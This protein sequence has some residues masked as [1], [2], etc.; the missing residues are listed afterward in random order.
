MVDPSQIHLKFGDHFHSSWVSE[1]CEGIASPSGLDGLFERLISHKEVNLLPQQAISL[2][3]PT[4]TDYDQEPTTVEEQEHLINALLGHQRN[5]AKT[6]SSLSNFSKVLQKRL[7]VLQRV[8]QAVSCKH[9]VQKISPE[10]LPLNTLVTR[11]SE[12]DKNNLGLGISQGNDA[13]LELGVKTGINILFSLL[14]QNWV[15]AKQTGQFSFCND[16][17]QTAISVVENFPPLSLSNETKLTPLG[18]DSLNQINVFLQQAASPNSEADLTGQRLAAELMIALA[19]QRGSLRYVLGWIEMSMKISVSVAKGKNKDKNA[20]KINWQAFLKIITDMI[21]PMG[22]CTGLKSTILQD[23]SADDCGLVSLYYAAVV[24]LEELYFLASD[25]ASNCCSGP[26]ENCNNSTPHS[27]ANL[28]GSCGEVYVWGSNCTHQLAE[29]GQEKITS[30]KYSAVFTDCQQVEAGQ[31]CTFLIY[32]D[33]TVGACGKG[34]YGRLGLGDS[35]NC[36]VPKK[37]LFE[38]KCMKKISSS[39]GSDGHSLALTT[40]GEV[41]SWGDGDYGKLGHGTHSTQKIPKLVKGPLVGKIVKSVSAGYR[42][43]AAVTE[44]GELYT[45]GD[46]EFGR[47]GHDYTSSK[48]FPT[49][50]QSIESVGMVACGGSHTLAV[51]QDG[52]TIW[53]F[54][55]GENGKL[56]HGDTNRQ[57]KPKVIEALTGLYIRKVSCGSQSS[58]AVTSSGQ[59]YAWGC[60]AILGCGSAE[61]TAL[62]PRLVEDLQSKRVVDIACGDSHVIALTHE[63]EVYAWGNNAMGQCGQG[64]AQSPITR[65]KRVIG[66]EGV[67]IHQVS[68]GTSHSVAWTAVPTDRPVVVWQKPFCVDL[69]EATF[70][71]IRTFLENFCCSFDEENPP[72]PFHSH[73]EHRHFVQLC[74]KMLSTHLSLAQ[75]GGLTSS[76]LGTQAPL[77]RNLL[78]RLL[79]SNIPDHV[80]ETVSEILKVG[81]PL[82]LPPLRERM[83]LLHSLLPQGQGRW[84]SLSRG[85]QMQ[86]SLILT[87][88]YDNNHISTLL[89]FTDSAENVASPKPPEGSIDLMLAEILMKT[90]LRNLAN[91]TEEALDDLEKNL[92]VKEFEPK[93][94]M[95]AF[96]HLHNLLSSLH[97][98]LLA[99]CFVQQPW[100]PHD[101]PAASLL[102]KHTSL[103]C[104]VTSSLLQKALLLVQNENCNVGVMSAVEDILYNSP[105]GAMMFHIVNALLL[106]PLDWISELLPEILPLLSVIDQLC[107]LLP[108]TESLE[109]AELE[110]NQEDVQE[111]WCWLV[112]MERTCA[113]LI[114]QCL[115]GMLVG[116]QMSKQEKSCLPWLE[117]PVFGNGA[118]MSSNHTEEVI[119]L[120]LDCISK[121]QLVGLE[122]VNLS[123]DEVM[124]LEFCCGQ[125]SEATENLWETMQ[126]YAARED[127][128]TSE[129]S[130]DEELDTMTR[131]L[132]SALLKHCNLVKV[133]LYRRN[134]PKTLLVIFQYVFRVRSCLMQHHKAKS[135]PSPQQRQPSLE[136]GRPNSPEF[137]ES[138][139]RNEGKEVERS[140]EVEQDQERE[141]VVSD[142]LGSDD[143]GTIKDSP[144]ILKETTFEEE[145]KK[146]QQR[147]L[148]LLLGVR[149]AVTET[150]S[151]SHIKKSE[152]SL[153]DSSRSSEVNTTPDA[154]LKRRGSVPDLSPSSKFILD[155]TGLLRRSEETRDGTSTPDH[156]HRDTNVASLQRVKEM[157]RRLRWQQERSTVPHSHH[158]SPSIKTFVQQVASDLCKFVCGEK[159]GNPTL[160][161]ESSFSW[162]VEPGEMARALD[163]QQKKAESRLRALNQI[164]ELLSTNSAKNESERT[165]TPSTLLSS[166]HIQLLMGCFSFGNPKDMALQ[167]AQ[168]YHYQDEIRA[169]KTEVQQDIQLTVHQIYELLVSALIETDKCTII[170]Q[171]ETKKLLLWTIFS[172]TMKYGPSDISLAVS[173]GLLPLLFK[174]TL[175]NSKMTYLMPVPKRCLTL[176]QFDL[177]LQC[178]SSNLLNLITLTSGAYCD[179]LGSGVVQSIVDLLWNQLGHIWSTGNV[180][181]QD[182]QDSGWQSSLGNFLLFLKRVAAA[183]AIQK[184]LTSRKWI[185]RILSLTGQFDESGSIVLSNMRSRLIAFSVL[186]M[187][188]S[189]CGK[190]TDPNYMQEV[191]EDLFQCLADNMWKIPQQLE[192]QKAQEKKCGLQWKLSAGADL[193]LDKEMDLEET[194]IMMQNATFDIEKCLNCATE[195]PQVLVHSTSGKGYGLGSTAMVSGCYKWKILIV[196]E[197]KGNEGT[198]VGVSKW[199]IRD[200]THRTTTDMWLYRAYSGNLYHGGEQAMALNGFTQGDFIT[201]VLDMDAK[202]LSFGKNGEDPRIAF[203]D[204]DASELYPCVMFYSG[205]PGEKIKMTDMQICEGNKELLPGDPLCAPVTSAVMEANISMMR[206]LHQNEVW[207]GAINRKLIDQLTKIKDLEKA[208]KLDDFAQSSD[209]KEKKED[210]SKPAGEATEQEECPGQKEEKKEPPPQSPQGEVTVDYTDEETMKTL[211]SQVWPSL[212]LIGGLDPGLRVGGSCKHKTTSKKGTLMGVSREGSATVKVHWDDGDS[213]VSDVLLTKIEAL[214]PEP[215]QANNLSGLNARHLESLMKLACLTEDIPSA[216]ANMYTRR[217]NSKVQMAKQTEMETAR[218]TNALMRKLDEDIARVLE[219]EQSSYTG[220]DHNADKKTVKAPLVQLE[221]FDLDGA[222]DTAS[223]TTSSIS[224]RFPDLAGSEGNSATNNKSNFTAFD[225]AVDMGRR[226]NHQGVDFGSSSQESLKEP[227]PGESSNV[228]EE[229]EDHDSLSDFQLMQRSFIQVTALKA[230]NVIIQCNKFTEMLLVP[231]SD[232]MADSSKALVDGTV[233]RRDED[234]KCGLRSLMKKMVKIALCNASLLRVFTVSDLERAQSVLYQVLTRKNAEEEAGIPELKAKLNQRGTPANNPS[235]EVKPRD[236]SLPFKRIEGDLGSFIIP[237]PSI[238]CSLPLDLTEEEIDMSPDSRSNMQQTSILQFLR[239]ANE[240]S[241]NTSPRNQRNIAPLAT[242]DYSSPPPNEEEETEPPPLPAPRRY[243]SSVTP[244]PVWSRMSSA[245]KKP[246]HPPVRARSPSPP[247]PPIAAPLLEMGFSIQAIKK[248]IRETNVNGRE[249]SASGINTLAMWMLE[250]PES[251]AEPAPTKSREMNRRGSLESLDRRGLRRRRPASSQEITTRGGEDAAED[252]ESFGSLFLRRHRPLTRTRH[253]NLRCIGN[254][255]NDEDD[256]TRS[257]MPQPTGEEGLSLSDYYN[258][259]GM[260]PDSQDSLLRPHSLADL[261]DNILELQDEIYNQDDSIEDLFNVEHAEHRDTWDLFNALR[262]ELEDQT[263]VTCELCQ[264][265]TTNFNRHMRSEHPG[266]M[267]SCSQHGYRSNGTYV[268]GWFGGRCGSGH[269][270]YLMCP[271]CRERYLEARGNRENLLHSVESSDSQ[272]SLKAPDLLEFSEQ[273]CQEPMPMLSEIAQSKPVVEKTDVLMCKIGLTDHKPVPEPVKFSESDPLGSS[274]LKSASS[275][276][277]VLLTLSSFAKGSRPDGRS[278]TLGEQASHISSGED[279]KVSLYRITSTMQIMIARSMVTKVLSVLASSGPNCSLPSALDYIGLSDIMTL[280]QFMCLCATGKVLYPQNCQPRDSAESLGHLTTAI[281]TLVQDSPASLKQLIQLCTQELMLAAMGGNR[282]DVRKKTRSPSPSQPSSMFTVTQSLVTL[283]TRNKWVSSVSWRTQNVPTSECE[284]SDPPSSPQSLDQGREDTPL[285]LINALAACVLSSKLSP[286]YKQ[287]AVKEFIQCLSS[288]SPGQ[289]DQIVNQVDWGR[290]MCACPVFKLEAHQNRLAHCVWSSKKNMLATSGYDGTLRVWSLPNRTH[291]F[292]QQTCVF[293][294]GDEDCEELNGNLLSSICWSSTGKYLAGAMDNIVNIWTTGGGKGHMDMQPHFV[295]VLTWPE[296]KGMVGGCLGLTMDSLLIGRLD[297]SLAYI[298]VFDSSSF[299]RHELEHCYRENVSVTQIAWFEEDRPFAVSYSDGVISLCTKLEIDRPHHTR[300]YDSPIICMK[301]DPTGHMLACCADG[302]PDLKIW[303]GRKGLSLALRL[304][305]RAEVSSLQ[306]CQTLGKGEDKELLLASGC[307]DGMVNVWVLNQLTGGESNLTPFNYQADTI[308][309]ESEEFCNPEASMSPVL[310]VQGHVSTITSLVFCPSALMLASGCDRGWLNIWS[311]SD[312]TLLQTH[313]ENGMVSDLCW[314]AEHGL[315]ACFSKSKDVVILHYT[316]DMLEKSRALS[317]CR[318]SLKQQGVWGLAQAPFLLSLLEKLPTLLQDQ[319]LYEKP[320]VVSGQQL[321]HSSYLQ[322]LAILAVGLEL[323]KPLCHELCAPHNRNSENTRELVIPEWQWL[324]S[325]SA[326]VKSAEAL[327]NR[328]PFPESF[329]MLNKDTQS[330]QDQSWDNGKWDLNMDVQIMNWAMQRPEDW[331]IG[332][333]CEAFLWGSGRNGQMCEGGRGAF[334]PVKVPSFACSQQIVCGQN[335]T[336]VVQN[337]GT[338]LACGEGSY[339]RLGQGNSDDLHSL[340]AISS[341]QGFVVTQLATSVGSDGHTL[342]VTESGEVFSWGDGDYGKLGHGNSDRQRRPR[343]IEALQGEEVIQLSCG[344]KHSAV[345]TADGKLFT[346]GNG[347]YGRLGLGTTTNKKLPTRVVA[348]ESHQIGYVA[349]G[350]N[351]TLC[352]SADGTNVW[353]FGDGDFG[354]LGQGN[355]VGKH[356]PT[357]IKALQ[358]HVIKKVACGTQFSVALSK[359]GKVFTWGQERLIGQPDSRG[360]SNSQPQEVTSLAGYFIEDVVCGAEHTLVLNSDGDVWG[361]G[362]NSEGQ[363]GL[364]HTNSPVREP[365]VVP[366]LTGKNVRQISAGRTHSAAWTTPCPPQRIPGVPVPLQLGTPDKIPASCSTLRES[367]IE[368]I[369]GRLKLLHHFS[370]LIYSSWRLLP[371]TT[372]VQGEMPHYARGMS[373]IVDGR[374]RPLLSPRVFSLPMVRAIGKTMVQGKN[375]GPPITVKR[376]S[377]RG[378]KCKPVFTQIG[379]QVIKLR[380]EELRLP[381]RAWKVKLIGEGADD[382]G[383]VF[384]DTITEMCQEL[385]TG[386]VPYF[387][388]TPNARNESGNNRDR[389]LLNPARFGEDDL[390]M[391]KFLGILFGVAIRTK[392]PL[393]LHLAPSVWKLLAGIPLRL[394]D[395]E[396]TDHIYIQSLRGILDIHESGVNETNFHEFIPL[397]CF[398]GQSADGSLVPVIPGGGTLQLNFHNRREYVE[399]VLNYRLQEMNR[400]AGAVREGMSWIVPVPLLTLL[401]PKNL[402]QLVCGMEEMS[403]DVL[404]KVVRYRGIDE[405]NEVVCWFWE[406][407]DSFSNEERIQFLRF[408]SGRTRLPANPSDISQRFQIMNS[409]RGANCLPTSQTCFFQLRLPNY[410]SKELLAEKLR[411]AIFNCRSIDMDN[412]MLT[413]NAENEQMSDEDIEEEDI[414]NPFV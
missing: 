23:I 240:R 258:V 404:R 19:A 226:N 219:Q 197:N 260:N 24:L 380:P 54:G 395:I 76:V 358:G 16:I 14:R 359:Y 104:S 185:S 237:P 402:E 302:E 392:K 157:L 93:M 162:E 57:L 193:N 103:M 90:I 354:K 207:A 333:K 228:L 200:Y 327:S 238:P 27:N 210:D 17:I 148:F 227:D 360:G 306:W 122:D 156:H 282:G 361:W 42:H 382:A 347:D 397:D 72:A 48:N 154:R 251:G 125:K 73:R 144:Q 6:V 5:L 2:K 254:L 292:L 412:Y 277:D 332:G 115:G 43:S 367:P 274:L 390:A 101:S 366:C 264:Q 124:L 396:E 203:E 56:G 133:A 155:P 150:L 65:P 169:A 284:D 121:H 34:S 375:Y 146:Y 188:L 321:V 82:L 215:F 399:A 10:E 149:P 108:E 91:E 135:S 285:N 389:F 345:V 339:G 329:R 322:H 147:C 250:H 225:E 112:D 211:C 44:D 368:D 174:L 212:V 222:E 394:E 326:A 374:L 31:F 320:K 25:Y 364:G 141:D 370:D 297:G 248:A 283:L 286:L 405:K 49:K 270:F 198:C 218:E 199:P 311:I 342:A 163:D 105:A 132:L 216:F 139:L 196:K 30:P 70:A 236:T 263:T 142:G 12:D 136:E 341:I 137:P 47:L 310:T 110:D 373:G 62:R 117:N 266:C 119:H 209:S 71:T 175:G 287:W 126:D 107:K 22:N 153:P 279:R 191:V 206:R 299:K 13:L 409:D 377:T 99:Y 38:K 289:A 371:L 37:P 413:R 79:D 273:A 313:M 290:D 241:S 387:I 61:Y 235:P 95:M 165:P 221:T 7:I 379:Q 173:C 381:A 109:A 340:T 86:L 335:C 87:S 355:T 338:V 363:L 323:D 384:D 177:I 55:G 111:K 40:G 114:G 383:G 176:A 182:I 246:P 151:L 317:V 281:G 190:D 343:Q 189:S 356:L 204:I 407:L 233:V 167:S 408:V 179:K 314:Y 328:T 35:N 362:N 178:S 64:H 123:S 298:D 63:S 294:R 194:K 400:Q 18:V 261:Y 29:G 288:Q 312:G 324:L 8:Y 168:L 152:E 230:L 50:V 88:L 319:Y 84:D 349:C 1:D 26:D 134:L 213:T 280:V 59:L 385:E 187:I 303:T 372:I 353:A 97:K 244:S 291:Q 256:N 129:I 201:V 257:E 120:V 265:E 352:V 184:H 315:A 68:A 21:N 113:T 170:K 53:S 231:K 300:A 69:Q 318:R 401:T 239:R 351:H 253:I 118:E 52:K 205:T 9:H 166:A 307:C 140:P 410:P 391:F 159:A 278:K 180:S 158:K 28:S 192:L 344:F 325:F 403:V 229:P 85:K 98:H 276:G 365:Q 217:L 96:P 388:P 309:E 247:P 406:V 296:H 208:H 234:F 376:L 160:T 336:F 308:Q 243:S 232:L 80:R 39:K 106:L 161:T 94:F 202:T 83:E 181:N 145:C 41:Y 128:D 58:L 67:K 131:C 255:D 20:G 272:S 378:K 268:D 32:S 242:V 164:K 77:L 143:E 46:G 172:L 81:A 259:S 316:S 295:S 36:S 398:E 45:W 102:F 334:V 411:Y 51:S 66:L 116:D 60:G 271:D 195:S 220:V 186:E 357:K 269:P 393:D 330:C 275:S 127:W 78:F 33:G 4:L 262:R 386:I 223:S 331:L 224:P 100:K 350:L 214:E 337:N 171:G 267:G 183:S 92:D 369:Q 249:V 15:L 414:L 293:N 130:N 245:A 11:K 138:I 305:H 304:H 346:F 74:L 89:G 3:G 252:P 301:W 348:L 75:V